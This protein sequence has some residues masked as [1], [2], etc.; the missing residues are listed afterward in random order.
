METSLTISAWLLTYLIHSTLLIGGV[1]IGVRLARPRLPEVRELLWKAAL[2]GAVLTT[3]AQSV[4]LP[5]HWGHVWALASSE[6]GLAEAVPSS[7]VEVPLSAKGAQPMAL[8]ERAMSETEPVSTERGSIGVLEAVARFFRWLPW[9]WL[10]LVLLGAL[11]LARSWIGLV[12][13][14]RDAKCVKRGETVDLAQNI[15][16]RFGSARSVEIWIT[17]T[18][19]GPMVTGLRRWRLFLPKGFVQ[20]LDAIELEA[21][22][23]HELAHL[24]RGDAW[25]LMAGQ[26]ISCL[27]FFQPLNQVARRHLRAEAEYL[28]DRRAL[29]VLPD[30]SGLAR[31]LVALGEWL[32][33]AGD[34]PVLHPLAAGMAGCRSTLGKRIESLLEGTDDRAAAGGLKRWAAALALAALILTS[35]AAPRAVASGPSLSS[36]PQPHSSMKPSIISKTAAIFASASLL[37]SVPATA[38]DKKPD[39]PAAAAEG[40][41]LPEGLHGFSGHLSGQLISKDEE[42]G[43]MVMKVGSL[44]HVWKNNKAPEPNLVVGRTVKVGGIHGKA[45]DVLVV[46]NPGDH[47]EIET[48]HLT[49]DDMLYLGEGMKKVAAPAQ[50]SAK[51]GGGEVLNGFRGM[52]VGELISKD[53]EKGTLEVKIARISR[54][55]KQNK[56]EHPEQAVGQTWKVNGVTGKWLDTLLTLKV[57]DQV[58]V[59]AF[60]HRGEEL[61]FVGEWLKKVEAEPAANATGSRDDLKGFRGL[62]IAKL[63]A[64]DVEKGEVEIQIESIKTAFKKSAA[65]NA[66]GSV[67]QKWKVRGIAGKWVDSLLVLNVGDRIELAAFHN[68]GEVLDFPGEMLRK[69]E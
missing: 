68:G 60:H 18:I 13:L 62:L 26:W 65:P 8:E 53:Q 66:A 24:V 14:R 20:R 4:L 25:W 57:G 47:L 6:A 21:V 17:P 38:E 39:A 23:A 32:V 12:R 31:S 51:G 27:F 46:L 28:A 67:G 10:A 50:E 52:F 30:E 56:A 1:W 64:K 69:A 45:L 59:E 49:G 40:Q 16:N 58:E 7:S 36:Q 9:V 55:W 34:R 3:L 19:Q 42:K 41:K 11:R 22:I 63:L 29:N 61:D 44:L 48:K 54:V 5:P 2:V 33:G 37:A 43:S 35:L 15:L